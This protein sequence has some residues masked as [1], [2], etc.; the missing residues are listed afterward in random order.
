MPSTPP[1]SEASCDEALEILVRGDR[2]DVEEEVRVLPLLLEVHSV[3]GG[4]ELR[5]R[6]RSLDHRRDD[7]ADADLLRLEQV[8]HRLAASDLHGE[9]KLGRAGDIDEP[10]QLLHPR[11]LR[12]ELG[13][14]AH[15]PVALLADLQQL[16]H[17]P[18][19]LIHC[20]SATRSTRT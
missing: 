20:S 7:V 18:L 15:D 6:V 2:L 12:L 8:A 1:D 19:G 9:R 10:E 14:D 17:F 16:G 13:L 11:P 4:D 5:E 3:L